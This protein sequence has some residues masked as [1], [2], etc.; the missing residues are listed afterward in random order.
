MNTITRIAYGD[1]ETRGQLRHWKTK[2][3]ELR[4]FD[5]ALKSPA[6]GDAAITWS[7]A[8]APPASTRSPG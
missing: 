3:A 5:R 4:V 8:P 6:V 7:E 2:L 1:A